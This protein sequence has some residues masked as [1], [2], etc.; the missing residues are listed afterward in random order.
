MSEHRKYLVGVRDGMFSDRDYAIVTAPGPD[1][2][3]EQFGRLVAMRDE[4]FPAV[5]NADFPEIF[6]F[7]TTEEHDAFVQGGT[8]LAS[9][10]LFD[11]RVRKSFGSHQDYADL[12]LQHYWG[13]Q[14]Q[15]FPP[16]MLLCIWLKYLGPD[17]RAVPLESII[18]VGGRN[19][20]AQE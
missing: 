2:A 10:E 3:I 18:E 5:I 16:D 6:W 19:E 12:Y 11:S 4:W 15:V 20:Q 17:Y 7:V 1:E 8:V 14:D 13:D 9:R